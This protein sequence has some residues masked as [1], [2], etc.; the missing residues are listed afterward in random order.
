MNFN[1]KDYKT[2][3]RKGKMNNE[4]QNK[5]ERLA[6]M[7]EKVEHIMQNIIAAVHFLKR[8]ALR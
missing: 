2:R 4:L 7:G 1:G 3:R 6:T 8:L 5:E